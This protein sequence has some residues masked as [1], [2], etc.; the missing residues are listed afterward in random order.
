MEQAFLDKLMNLGSEK[1]DDKK[2]ELV[3][4][5]VDLFYKTLLDAANSGGLTQEKLGSM[6]YHKGV[7]S[8][9]IGLLLLGYSLPIHG[10]DGLFGPETAAAVNKF[11]SDNLGT[12]GGATK[13]MLTKLISLLQEKNISSSDIS[14]YIDTV[15]TGGGATFTDL[16]ITTDDGYKSYS[17]ICQK[18]IDTKQPNPL[19]ITGDMLAYGARL[20]FSQFHKYVPPELALAQLYIE[21]GIGNGNLS[22]KPI[23][24]RNPFNVGNTDTGQTEQNR[25]VQEG[26]NEYY[27]LIARYYLGRGKTASD[28]VLNFVNKNGDR[29]ASANDYETKLNTIAS[30]INKTQ[31]NLT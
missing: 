25:S 4:Q 13:D 5:D 3:N 10:V 20:A 22:S 18:F 31:I 24:T 14:K 21:G 11:N 23:R 30:Q 28:L 6:T 12:V 15:N 19:G 9:Q 26:I 2:A 8:M 27:S 29:Y 17:S 1:K 16:D 7:E